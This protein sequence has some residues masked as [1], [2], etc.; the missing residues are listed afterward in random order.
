MA[1][2]GKPRKW[3]NLKG[4]IPDAAPSETTE[5]MA[6]VYIEKDGLAG[7]TMQEMQDE[8]VALE[9]EEEFAKLAESKRNITYKALELRILEEL[10]KVK[11]IAGTDMWRGENKTFS[12]KFT[13][14]PTVTDPVA[15]MKWIHDTNQEA[16]LT[17]SAPRLK[18]IV[19]EALDTE[20]A[21]AM[22]PAQRAE[23]KPG[24]PASGAPPP[25]VAVFLQTGVH[26]TSVKQIIPGTAGSDPDDSPF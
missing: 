19:N 2:A 20:A 1:R 13:P 16:Q 8:W 17:L 22:T 5:W 15:L 18:S 12:P 9:E 26:H 10:Q 24:D 23:L 14:H 25:G 11:A 4:Q 7:K 21:V 3:S 6:K